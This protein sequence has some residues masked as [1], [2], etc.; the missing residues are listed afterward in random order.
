MFRWYY[1]ASAFFVLQATQA[2]GIADRL[3]YGDW[4]GKGGDKITQSLNLL[5]ILTSLALFGRGFRRLWSIRTGA[6]LALGLAGFLFCSAVWSIDPHV[7]VREAIL[8][9]FVVVGAIG[10]TSNLQADEFMEL[11][12]V[13]C[14]LAGAAS[15]VL[16]VV[17]PAKAFGGDGDFRGIFSQKNV[18]GE[19]MTVGVLATLHG[20]RAGTRR[21]RGAIMLVL[22]TI[23]ALASRSA[24]SCLTIFAFCGVDSVIVLFR[25]GGAARLLAVIV[26]VLVLPLVMVA[27]VFPDSALEMIGKDPTL[28][29]R[30][31]IWGY[32][33]TDI[34]Q[35]PWL[36]WGYLAFWSYSNPAAMEIADALHWV[37]PQ[38]HNG[39][40]EILLYVGVVGATSFVFLWARTVW[41]ALR[42]MRTSEKAVAI[43][44]LLSCTGIILV[45]I[46][47]T[48]LI[49]PF[50]ASTSVF[51]ITGL[52]CERAVRAA[53]RRRYRTAAHTFRGAFRPESE[54]RLR[55]PG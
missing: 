37:V 1:W 23:V 18:L 43:S 10:I 25:K 2:T 50:E 17:S 41:L 5:L 42:C 26:I 51:F 22:L 27:A 33:I 15:L 47:E 20:I 28:T 38:S 44:S 32:V 12:A 45:G 36:G 16:L 55:Q 49:D 31:E 35:K 39:I 40:L 21:L 11:L 7:T 14:F 46:S 53:R 4:Q 13:I 29:G 24:T 9:L 3:V 6:I 54:R 34:Y 52:L 8:Y 48:V 19:A 30:T